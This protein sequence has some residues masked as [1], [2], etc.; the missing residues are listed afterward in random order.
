MHN[1][2]NLKVWQKAVELAAAMYK[3]TR[4]FPKEETY[5]LT[6]QIRRS[7]VSVGSNIAEGSGRST[8]KEFKYF[9]N[10]SYGSLCEL[11]TQ[12]VIAERLGYSSKEHNVLIASIDE[13]QKMLFS[14][15][16]SYTVNE[17]GSQYSDL[18]TQ[19]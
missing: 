8:D 13:L 15:I 3:E 11:E 1:Y 9:L 16:K 19:I 2:K 4:G 7:A 17:P 12:L 18:D 6:Q 14:L 5:G 10:V